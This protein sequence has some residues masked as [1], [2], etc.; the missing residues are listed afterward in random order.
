MKSFFATVL[1]LGTSILS[2]F[3]QI[4]DSKMSLPLE[5]EQTAR[6]AVVP[7]T[8]GDCNC[9]KNVL[10][11]GGFNNVTTAL[12]SS[13]IAPTS[14]PW[15]IG[16]LSPQW[17]NGANMGV[18]NKG[19][20][21]MWGNKT[22]FESVK[23]NN[24][25][26]GAKTYK[27]SARVRFANPTALSTFVRLRVQVG[28][29]V[30][31][32]VSTNITSTGSFVQVNGTFTVATAGN[33]TVTLQPENDY[34]QNNG[35]YVSWILVDNICIE[36]ACDCSKLPQQFTIAG[37]QFFCKPK[38]CNNIT[39]TYTAPTMPAGECYKYQWSVS[40]A[41]PFSGQGTNQIRL[42]CKNLQ[43][44]AYKIT[45]RITC[46]D[47]TVSNTIPLMVC[48]KPD[49]SFS[50]TTTG[51]GANLTPIGAASGHY[52]WMIEDKDNSCS[53]TS[54]DAIIAPSP[55]TT[56]T[57]AFTGL[58]NNKQYLVYHLA[59]NDCGNIAKCYSLQ[60]MC[61][62]FLP[63]LRAAADA[64][65]EPIQAISKKD[66]DRLN[67]LPQNLVKQL[68]EGLKQTLDKADQ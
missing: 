19:Y 35:A 32:Y 64:V 15:S 9:E 60:I 16:T 40:P 42:A 39:L 62:R 8:Q 21:A 56:P 23:Q 49:P 3:A 45:V 47:K 53:Y 5:P 52:W 22:V 28:P 30:A 27:I 37:P 25:P 61:F 58:I 31:N 18:C 12:G 59:Y 66:V 67:E 44:G 10:K 7:P 20:I 34:T 63:P 51:A 2:A 24:V 4:D 68:P 14:T 38:N 46:G 65:A 11:D 48:A 17:A 36:E 43:L 50:I 26:F 57:A 1:F 33:Y 55:V 13:N 6:I 41:V 29:G 54:G